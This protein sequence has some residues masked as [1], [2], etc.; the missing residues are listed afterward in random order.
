MHTLSKLIPLLAVSLFSG[1]ALADSYVYVVTG[2]SQFGTVD[3]N[4]GAFSA[5]GPSLI[6]TSGGLVPGGGGSLLTLGVDGNLYSINPSTGVETAVGATGIGI[7][8]FSLAELNGTLYATDLSNNIYTV[9]PVT[10]AATL[11]SAT[12]IPPDHDYPFTIDPSNGYT[13][14]CDE[15]LYGVGNSLYATYDE[16]EVS[17][18]GSTFNTLNS[19]DL[20]KVNPTT[21][22]ATEISPTDLMLDGSFYSNGS[23]YAFFANG[24]PPN[25]FFTPQLQLETIDL[26]NGDTHFVADVDPDAVFI[27]GATPVTPEPSSLI[28]LGTGLA[29]LALRARSICQR[30]QKP[31]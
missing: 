11:L 6:T 26:S 31:R 28:L 19:S 20:W 12:G 3:L 22:I 16:I 17:P 23:L 14:L 24:N 1:S 15:T 8:A 27:N 10:G 18:D 30:V 5:I 7:N 13:Y 29:A 9:N 2:A 4:N 21:G 25:N